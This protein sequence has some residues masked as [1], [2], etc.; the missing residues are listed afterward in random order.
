[1]PPM[2]RLKTKTPT[3][4]PIFLAWQAAETAAGLAP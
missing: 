4:F 3:V 1:M 2:C